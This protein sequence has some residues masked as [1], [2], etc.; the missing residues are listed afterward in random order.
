VI[1]VDWNTFSLVEGR[2]ALNLSTANLSTARATAIAARRIPD[3]MMPGYSHLGIDE[4]AG[5]AG[6][7]QQRN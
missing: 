5:H 1:G 7:D 3:S 4:A 2:F 6:N